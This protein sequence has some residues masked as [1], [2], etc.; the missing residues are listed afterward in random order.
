MATRRPIA[1]AAAW[2]IHPPVFGLARFPRGRGGSRPASGLLTADRTGAVPPRRPQHRCCSPDGS[3]E[4]D[5]AAPAFA[6][7]HRGSRP[8][9]ALVAVAMALLVGVTV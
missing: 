6:P 7:R 2:S 8:R 5:T 4:E 9:A 3:S 1:P